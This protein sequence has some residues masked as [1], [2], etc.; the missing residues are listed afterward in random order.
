MNDTKVSLVWKV[1]KADVTCDGPDGPHGMDWQPAA[2]LCYMDPSRGAA[3]ADIVCSRHRNDGAGA[4]WT[5]G[6]YVVRMN[7]F[8]EEIE[9]P[10]LEE[11]MALITVRYADTTQGEVT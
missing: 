4:L 9:M 6:R 2:R 11:A 7:G 5:P 10:S 3:V 8:N 1:F